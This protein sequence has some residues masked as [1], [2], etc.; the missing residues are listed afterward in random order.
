M[1]LDVTKELDIDGLTV[2]TNALNDTIWPYLYSDE[3]P[4]HGIHHHPNSFFALAFLKLKPLNLPPP[5]PPKAREGWFPKRFLPGEGFK[6]FLMQAGL[7]LAAGVALAVLA[8][9]AE[10]FLKLFGFMGN[11]MVKAGAFLHSAIVAF[12]KCLANHGLFCPIHAFFMLIKA[13]FKLAFKIGTW[14]VKMVGKFLLKLLMGAVKLGAFTFK[15]IGAALKTGWNAVVGLLGKIKLGAL[16]LSIGIGMKNVLLKGLKMLFITGPLMLFKAMKALPKLMVNIADFTVGA[17]SL[18]MVSIGKLA[19]GVPKMGVAIKQFFIKGLPKFF[20]MMFNGFG[21]L[22]MNLGVG[23]GRMALGAISLVGAI[24]GFMMSGIPGI[25][26]LGIAMGGFVKDIFLMSGK[27]LLNALD[28]FGSVMLHLGEAAWHFM[29]QIML[30]LGKVVIKFFEAA[31]ALTVWL[32]HKLGWMMIKGISMLGKMFVSFGKMFPKMMLGGFK[33][34]GDLVMGIPNF[35][36]MAV[37]G[38]GKIMKPIFAGMTWLGTGLWDVLKGIGSL[39]VAFG[40][41]GFNFFA[42]FSVG[43][44]SL[45]GNFFKIV[46]VN[47]GK[48]ATALPGF[49][50]DIGVGALNLAKVGI[51]S[52]PNVGGLLAKGIGG[53]LKMLKTLMHGAVALGKGLM[54]GI[55]AFL[56]MDIRWILTAVIL[57]VYAAYMCKYEGWCAPPKKPAWGEPGT[58]KQSIIRLS[59]NIRK[60]KGGTAAPRKTSHYSDATSFLGMGEKKK[61]E[62]TDYWRTKSKGEKGGTQYSS[63]QGMTGMMDMK[64]YADTDDV[65]WKTRPGDVQLVEIDR[66]PAIEEIQL[67]G[68]SQ[69]TDQWTCGGS[70]PPSPGGMFS[71]AP[72]PVIKLNPKLAPHS[73]MRV[74]LYDMDTGEIYWDAVYFPKQTGVID[75]SAGEVNGGLFS[76]QAPEGTPPGGWKKFKKLCVDAGDPTVHE[77]EL[78]ISKYPANGETH[79]NDH[80][81]AENYIGTAHFKLWILRD[82]SPPSERAARKDARVLQPQTF[83]MSEPAAALASISPDMGRTLSPPVTSSPLCSLQRLPA[84]RSFFTSRHPPGIPR[85]FSQAPVASGDSQK[86]IRQVSTR[87]RAELFFQQ[88]LSGQPSL[89]ATS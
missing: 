23:I 17:L 48:F 60:F 63:E 21:S 29:G 85:S 31:I 6:K 32:F 72:H 69:G 38:I 47:I 34:V 25:G 14:G 70:E 43:L 51:G 57:M 42:N 82:P 68:G 37:K 5:P 56:S 61:Q 50:K 83:S 78:N 3:P 46:G 26:E 73:S 64:T 24:P 77:L 11:L 55:K 45:M 13:A 59:E 27:V 58:H 74:Q 19:M 12:G 1:D 80:A 40:R 71:K 84:D 2:A 4:W 49:I 89:R 81:A 20:G 15:M 18:A 44:F 8:Y 79:G 76:L 28:M 35:L 53:L 88:P 54:S 52:L 75:D 10:D 39:T 9:F 87:R 16:L 66:S 36:K 7:M 67:T 65:E 41:L 30:S 22:M 62:D 86:A 33:L